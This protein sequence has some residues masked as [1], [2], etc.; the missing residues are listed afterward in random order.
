MHKQFLTS[1]AEIDAGHTHTHPDPTPMIHLTR[2]DNATGSIVWNF[3]PYADVAA[4]CELKLVT[5]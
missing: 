4:I 1:I 2:N 5:K 3:Y